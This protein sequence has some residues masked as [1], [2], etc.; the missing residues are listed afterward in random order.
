[1]ELNIISFN[2]LAP[3]FASPKWYPNDINLDL[4]LNS[5]TRL[6]KILSF[7][8]SKKFTPVRMRHFWQTRPR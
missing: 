3:I 4:L 8:E 5:R 1:M 7:I 2:I 6:I